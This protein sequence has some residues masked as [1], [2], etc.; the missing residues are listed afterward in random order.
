MVDHYRLQP[1]RRSIAKC[2]VII[3]YLNDNAQTPLNR[4]VVYM[5]YSQLLFNNYL[6][7]CCVTSKSLRLPTA[8]TV[9]RNCF[10]MAVL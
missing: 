9:T 7:N 10:Q 8:T 3:T 2:T 4:L 5:L 6:T 1:K